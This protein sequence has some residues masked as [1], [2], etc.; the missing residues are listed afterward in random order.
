MPASLRRQAIDAGALLALGDLPL[1]LDELLALQAMQRGI[2]GPGVDLEQVAG[3][4]AN[5]LADA[6]AM[7]G[8][9]AQLLEDQQVERALE[10]FDAV[11]V[12]RMPAMGIDSLYPWV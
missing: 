8:P 3:M 11:L 7:A 4:R 2:E 6:V 10:Q 5:R 9:P 1:R 12:A